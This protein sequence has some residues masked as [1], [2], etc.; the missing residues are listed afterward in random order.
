MYVVSPNSF[1]IPYSIG[2]KYIDKALC[3]LRSSVNLMPKSVFMKLGMGVARPTTVILQLANHSHVRP[4]GKVEDLLVKVGKF[5]FPTNLLILDCEADDKAPIILGRP[6]LATGRILIDSTVEDTELCYS[7][8]IQI[9][10]FLHLQEEDREEVDD[11]P[12]KEQQIKHSIPRYALEL[13]P[14]PSHLKYVYLGAND[15][16]PV[17]ISF[18]LNANQEL[19]VANLLQQYKKA[20]GR[21]NPAM[22]K[23]VMKEI[24]KWL[25]AGIICPKS[26]SSWVSLVQ[27]VPKKGGMTVVTNEAN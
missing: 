4:E 25:D 8:S 16:L 27:C 6:F 26:D 21:L 23:V 17:I 19:S 15:T 9:D 13:K 3:D 7:N 20:L 22:K 24:I 10:D 14:L 11:L 1:I 2:D 5:V 18:Q 12:L